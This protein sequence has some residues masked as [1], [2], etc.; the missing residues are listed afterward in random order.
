[1]T[2]RLTIVIIGMVAVFACSFVEASA[3][4]DE[5]RENQNPDPENIFSLENGKL[6]RVQPRNDE[7]DYNNLQWAFDHVSSGG[8]VVLEAGT[9]FLGDAVRAPRRTVLI[10]KGLYGQQGHLPELR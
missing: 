4:V 2:S 10:R 3:S 7:R 5:Y 9:F 1:M 8:D 6:I